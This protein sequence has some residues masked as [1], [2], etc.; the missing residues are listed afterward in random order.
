MSEPSI[1]IWYA[2]EENNNGVP[3]PGTEAFQKVMEWGCPADTA[4]NN[5]NCP[6][7]WKCDDCPVKRDSYPLRPQHIEHQERWQK[8]IDNLDKIGIKSINTE[9]LMRENPEWGTW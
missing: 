3:I 8:V 2:S 6:W 7:E 1:P 9:H 4:Y 5:G